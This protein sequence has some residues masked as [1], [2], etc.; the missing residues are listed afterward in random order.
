MGGSDSKEDLSQISTVIQILYNISDFRNYFL[1][2]QYEENDKPENNSK[3]YLSILMREIVSKEPNDINF[4]KSSQKI[5]ECLKDK[6]KLNIGS[7]PG[8]NLIIILMVLKYEEKLII[9]ESWEKQVYKTP[10]LLNNCIND[11]MALND[12]LMQNRNHFNTSFCGMFFGIFLTKRKFIDSNNIFFFYDFY[13]T[14]ELNIPL[15]YQNMINERKIFINN[16]SN[17]LPQLNLIDCIMEMMQTHTGNFNGKDCFIEYNMF[18][19]PNYLIFLLKSS[20]PNFDDFRGNII[21]P[22]NYNFSQVIQNTQSNMFKLFGIINQGRYQSKQVEGKGET[23]SQNDDDSDN[24]KFKAIF[25]DES[26]N[27]YCYYNKDD[28]K[29]NCQLQINDTEYY[30]HILIYKRC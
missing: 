14:Y 29:K 3:K 18:N 19:A 6:Y 23:W 10:Q 20:E 22:E 9:T 4:N 24:K 8:E 11:K 17:Q 26:N 5:E 21:F 27:Q 30:H 25:R 13:C 12:I 28:E 15:I 16:N 1:Q 2:K 7:T